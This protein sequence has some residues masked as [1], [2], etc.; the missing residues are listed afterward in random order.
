MSFLDRLEI[1]RVEAER[2]RLAEEAALREEAMRE[3]VE[4]QSQLE[5]R[6]KVAQE[7]ALREA[8]LRTPNPDRVQNALIAREES[9][10]GKLVERLGKILAD[11]KRGGAKGPGYDIKNGFW[12]GGYPEVE[13]R[14]VNSV[15]DLAVWD[16]EKWSL[17][18]KYVVVETHPSGDITFVGGVGRIEVDYDNWKANR[19]LL[20]GNLEKVFEFPQYKI[21]TR[22]K[23]TPSWL[24]SSG[25]YRRG[26]PGY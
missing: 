6:E 11:S 2:K 26:H 12:I 4:R 24:N 18:H 22:L 21:N 13:S 5:E 19:H 23:G 8:L 7:I 20:E 3:A 1:E 10:V 14:D 17:N 16:M 25:G 15:V 9:G